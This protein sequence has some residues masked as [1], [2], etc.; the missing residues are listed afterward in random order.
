MKYTVHTCLQNVTQ[1]KLS[2]KQINTSNFGFYCAIEK[3]PKQFINTFIIDT[4]SGIRHLAI[5]IQNTC[6]YLA[7]KN[8]ISY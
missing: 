2:C 6:R 7:T 8:Q 5:K 1:M 4:E 3:D